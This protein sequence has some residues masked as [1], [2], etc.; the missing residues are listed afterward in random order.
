[1]SA[2][3]WLSSSDFGREAIVADIAAELLG[4]RAVYDDDM[5]PAVALSY[6]GDEVLCVVPPIP[7]RDH[8][9][10][11]RTDVD[12]VARAFAR[13]IVEMG[14]ADAEVLDRN[15]RKAL[16]T[17]SEVAA[18]CGRSIEDVEYTLMVSRQQIQVLS[19]G[20]TDERLLRECLRDM[21]IVKAAIAAREEIAAKKR[22]ALLATQDQCIPGPV[23]G[24]R[25][26]VLHELVFGEK[27]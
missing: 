21:P 25:R 7:E 19:G 18:A 26:I 5:R 1:M 2:P 16:P 27:S 17:I 4:A 3:R 15:L 22:P 24:I 6:Q 10:G 9:T 23:F 8:V 20:L 11:R 12:D 14:Y 13:G